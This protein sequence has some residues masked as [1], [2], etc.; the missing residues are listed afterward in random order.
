MRLGFQP[1][2]VETIAPDE[3]GCLVF[4]S[5]RLIAVLVRLSDAHGR[6]MGCWYLEQGFGKLDGPVHPIFTD[7]DEAQNWVAQRFG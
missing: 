5:N 3:E 4:A 7:L 1:V 6:I 2:T